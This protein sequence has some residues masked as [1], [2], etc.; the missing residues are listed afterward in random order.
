[1]MGAELE[2]SSEKR[3]KKR[4]VPK[5]K[6]KKRATGQKQETAT[7][8]ENKDKERSPRSLSSYVEENSSIAP[9]RFV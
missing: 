4:R 8:F 2:V 7:P 9:D 1:M 5:T 6:S 3:F